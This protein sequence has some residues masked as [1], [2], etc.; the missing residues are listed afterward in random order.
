MIPTINVNGIVSGTI[1]SHSE[2]EW[3]NP[4]NAACIVTFVGSWC[5][6]NTYTVPPAISPTSPGRCMAMTL[7]VTG[8]YSFQ[9]PCY[10]GPGP[11]HIHVGD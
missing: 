2:F 9:S 11:P 1:R 3:I 10:E 4:T 7:N 5:T 6:M 8:N